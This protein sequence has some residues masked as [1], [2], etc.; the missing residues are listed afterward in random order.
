[1]YFD[2]P[3]TYLG[4]ESAN[5]LFCGP[6]TGVSLVEF[7]IPPRD[8]SVWKRAAKHFE[9]VRVALLVPI[10]S[11]GDPPSRVVIARCYNYSVLGR[12]K[13]SFYPS[14]EPFTHGEKPRRISSKRH[15]SADDYIIWFLGECCN[16]ITEPLKVSFPLG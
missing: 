13:S 9:E 2:L 12:K 1:S 15:V 11:I 6:K 10:I 16:V 8:V 5:L 3:E 14:D 4:L 7:R